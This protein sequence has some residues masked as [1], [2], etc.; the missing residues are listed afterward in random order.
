VDLRR[1]GRVRLE[2]KLRGQGVPF[3]A[4]VAMSGGIPRVPGT[5]V[6]MGRDPLSTPAALLHNL[7]HNRVLHEHVVH[8]VVR[9]EDVPYVDEA[10]RVT[11]EDLGEGFFRVVASYGFMETPQVEEVMASPA[12]AAAGLD[13]KKITYFLSRITLLPS[14][15]LG[16]PSAERIFISLY[17][18]S[19]RPVFYFGLEPNHVVELGRQV[20]LSR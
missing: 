16:L 14:K 1:R 2:E 3:E 13:A 9:A 15:P 11:A 17:K 10:Q 5:A 4:F 7:K 19:L 12:I 6:F 20:K 18:N 8:L